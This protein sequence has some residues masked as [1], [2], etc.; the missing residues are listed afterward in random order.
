[1]HLLILIVNIL[2]TTGRVQCAIIY[3]SA[4]APATANSAV[5]DRLFLEKLIIVV[6]LAKK[7][8]LNLTEGH[9]AMLCHMILSV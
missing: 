4:T 1:M 9:A 6:I 5:F 2:P 3:N 7:H 8:E